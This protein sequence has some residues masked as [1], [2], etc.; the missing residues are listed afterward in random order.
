MMKAG[1]MLCGNGGKTRHKTA[2]RL[3]RN[4]QD[5]AFYTNCRPTRDMRS[6]VRTLII[7]ISSY[8]KPSKLWL[9]FSDALALDLHQRDWYHHS[10]FEDEP[11]PGAPFK[12]NQS[13]SPD[14]HW[15]TANASFDHSSLC[16]PNVRPFKRKLVKVTRLL[17]V[18]HLLI[19]CRLLTRRWILLCWDIWASRTLFWSGAPDTKTFLFWWCHARTASSTET[20][21]NV[22][23]SGR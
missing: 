18:N 7:N 22:G 10:Y 13:T 17:V 14:I 2:W 12:D 4:Y 1:D 20:K 8:E 9:R 5:Y 21:I 16:L 11:W 23:Q 19:A 3:V 15:L 6:A